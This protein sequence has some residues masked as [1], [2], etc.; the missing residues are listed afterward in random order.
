MWVE[1]IEGFLVF[2]VYGSRLGE[3]EVGVVLGRLL[4]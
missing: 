1:N 3:L 4:T 2:I